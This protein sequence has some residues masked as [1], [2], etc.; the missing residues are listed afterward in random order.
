MQFGVEERT[1]G[2]ELDYSF[3]QTLSGS[4]HC[5]SAFSSPCLCVSVFI[6]LSFC[7][8]A[9]LRLAGA[10]ENS[11]DGLSQHLAAFT[12]SLD[13]FRPQVDFVRRHDASATNSG[14]HAQCHVADAIATVLHAA[15][16]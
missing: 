6:P 14:G 16:R 8:S 7:R 10:S 5:L 12:Q 2:D 1:R 3:F 9:L 11:V 13:F 4:T 15:H